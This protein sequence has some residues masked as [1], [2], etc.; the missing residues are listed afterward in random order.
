MLN[1]TFFSK[2]SYF[3]NI[4][5]GIILIFTVAALS[6]ARSEDAVRMTLTSDQRYGYD[7]APMA[8]ALQ[9]LTGKEAIVIPLDG[10]EVT[11]TKWQLRLEDRKA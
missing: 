2:L 11:A 7:V 1:A 10:N 3:L 8:Y 9:K 6:K 5:F 4:V